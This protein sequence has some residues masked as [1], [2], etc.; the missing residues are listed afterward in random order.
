ML[1]S[2]RGE[3]L[4]EKVKWINR[5]IQGLGGKR[6]IS[7]IEGS[8]PLIKEMIRRGIGKETFFYNVLG[9]IANAFEYLQTNPIRGYLGVC[10][11]L[12]KFNRKNIDPSN[13]RIFWND[14]VKL[15]DSVY[16]ALMDIKILFPSYSFS[17]GENFWVAEFSFNEENILGKP[18][19]S[20]LFDS[21]NSPLERIGNS[22]EPY[23][24][25]LRK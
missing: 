8:N 23:K 16:L 15:F 21:S 5:E 9:G 7:Q 25:Y 6:S 13:Q 11:S 1:H 3:D 24:F 22:N 2:N 19:V 14:N 17:K 18:V 10:C 20:N 4:E 12:D